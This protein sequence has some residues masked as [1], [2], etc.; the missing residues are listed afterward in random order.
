MPVVHPS[1][2]VPFAL[3]DQVKT[4]LER[5]ERLGVITPTD[6]PTDWVNSMVV[7]KKRNG[8]IRLCLDPWDLNR[9]VK[10]EHFKMPICEEI[11]AQFAGA[12]Y[13]SK[14]DAAQGFWQLELDKPSSYLCT[15]NMPF[16][17][18]RYLCLP[19]GI[20]SAPGVYYKT[21][22]Q[23]FEGIEGVSTIVDD[24]IVYGATKSDHDRS[25]VKTFGSARQPNLKLNKTK[26]EVGV[27]ELIFIGDE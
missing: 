3:H 15:F 25:L 1:R 27:K 7:V 18:Y 5:M 21:I 4:E 22:H 10:R 14:L 20:S 8:A 16:G 6:R 12:K 17:R 19:F 2:K 9:A 26:C 23:L 13:F 11:M 24:L